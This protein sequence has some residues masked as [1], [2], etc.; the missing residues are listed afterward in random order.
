MEASLEA[1]FPHIKPPSGRRSTAAAWRNRSNLL[2]S[3][4]SKVTSLI[5]LNKPGH[6]TIKLFAARAAQCLKDR[7]GEK[8]ETGSVPSPACAHKRRI[9][10]KSM[11]VC[12]MYNI[13]FP[14]YFHSYLLNDL[15]FW[16]RRPPSR[17]RIWCSEDGG[18]KESLKV[19][20]NNVTLLQI[21]EANLRRLFF[22]LSFFPSFF[23]FANFVCERRR[24]LL[25][26]SMK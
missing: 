25:Q 11:S 26:R 20:Q 1:C 21:R 4:L 15:H 19:D 8:S 23:F 5:P 6:K 18:G 12:V 3:D 2:L 7:R 9:R 17:G 22:F 13:P 10:T 16:Q 24:H 14:P